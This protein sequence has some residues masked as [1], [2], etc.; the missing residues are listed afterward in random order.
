MATSLE[1]VTYISGLHDLNMRTLTD[2]MYIV[3]WP[4]EGHPTFITPSYRAQ[5]GLFIDDVRSY[6]FYAR[7]EVLKDPRGRSLVDRSPIPLLAEVLD[8]KGLA[9]GRIG[10]EKMHFPVARY[11]EL[12]ALL[13]SAEFVDCGSLFDEA[14][15]V[16]TAAEIDLLRQ[17]A[18]RRSERSTTALS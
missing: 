6:D 5:A 1:N 7:D 15:M 14:R 11:E 8:E 4:A 17:L 9:T 16:K 13:P 3:V 18:L 12:S 2:R 10:L